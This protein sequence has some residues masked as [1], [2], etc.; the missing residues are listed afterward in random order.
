MDETEEERRKWISEN[1][2]TA[3]DLVIKYPSL[4]C[5][6]G[7]GVYVGSWVC[8]SIGASLRLAAS[9]TRSLQ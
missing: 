9:W 4:K 8:P 2:P 3:S 1:G 7:Y 6:N 5:Q